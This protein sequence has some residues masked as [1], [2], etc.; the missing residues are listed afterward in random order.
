MIKIAIKIIDMAI[1]KIRLYP[2][3]DFIIKGIRLPAIIPTENNIVSGT[4]FPALKIFPADEI[5]SGGMPENPRPI[6]AEPIK[7]INLPEEKMAIDRPIM[8]IIE[9]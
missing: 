3:I 7:I 6:I 5:R 2:A 8:L 1:D 4:S 9:R